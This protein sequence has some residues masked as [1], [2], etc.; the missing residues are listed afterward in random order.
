LLARQGLL[1][2]LAG[3]PAA[4]IEAIG[5]VQAQNWSTAPVGL[6]ARTG[7]RPD[8]ARALA[9]REL[10]YG[11]LLRGTLHIA[12]AGQHPSYA[13]VVEA[14]GVSAAPPELAD[15]RPDLHRFA[16]RPKS[17]EELVEFIEQWVAQH[18]PPLAAAELARQRQYQWRPVRRWSGLVR[19]PEDGSW[20]ARAP[21]TQVASP[22]S[23]ARWPEPA[24]ALR[25][26]IEWHLRGFGPAAPDDVAAWIGFK[27]PPV[28]AAMQAMALEP[29][30]D[31]RGRRLYDLPGAP[32]PDPDLEAPPRLLPGFDNVIL[33]YAPKNRGRILPDAYRERLY[34]RANLQ[35]LPAILVDGMV[36]GTWSP[37]GGLQPFAKLPKAVTAE[38][39]ALLAKCPA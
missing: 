17:G 22:A 26:V 4:V 33:A 10:V 38:L 13:A 12:S 19:A 7:R 14:S 2:P 18:R 8:L 28:R 21:L 27:T 31:E 16:S 32:R 39:Q 23:P 30:E 34:Q 1:K 29:L 20:G 36:A 3:G 6:W 37:K 25:N 35:W 9:A 5:P 11:F 24:D 15:L